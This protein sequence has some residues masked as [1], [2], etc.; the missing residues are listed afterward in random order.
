MSYIGVIRVFNGAPVQAEVSGSER[1]GAL[2]LSG[3]N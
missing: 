1:K 3:K 2:K